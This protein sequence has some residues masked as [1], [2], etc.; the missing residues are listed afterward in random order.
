MDMLDKRIVFFPDD[1]LVYS[2]IVEN[3]SNTLY[4]HLLE[5][6]VHMLA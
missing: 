5:K 4:E 3:T 6:G 2:K 1:I